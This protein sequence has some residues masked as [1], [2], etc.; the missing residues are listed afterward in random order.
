MEVTACQ[1]EPDH[2]TAKVCEVPL[3]NIQAH[4]AGIASK[5]LGTAEGL[6]CCCQVL[7]CGSASPRIRVHKSWPGVMPSNLWESSQWSVPTVLTMFPLAGIAQQAH[8]TFR[9]GG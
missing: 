2:Q 9:E 6:S 4:V 5:A 3:N 7:S 1:Q 8:A